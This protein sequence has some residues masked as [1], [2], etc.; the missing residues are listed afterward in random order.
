M[1]KP[2][3]ALVGT[4]SFL[5]LQKLNEL[6]AQMPNDVQRVDVDGERAELAEVLD[7][8]PM[9]ANKGFMK[10]KYTGW[11]VAYT[12]KPWTATNHGAN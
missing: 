3:Y 1:M 12:S 8:T 11:E 10:K 6:L 5:Q 4:D 9:R 7:E 2:V